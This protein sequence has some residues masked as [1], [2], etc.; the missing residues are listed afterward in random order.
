M[1]KYYL[2]QSISIGGFNKG[3]LKEYILEGE[4]I[5]LKSQAGYATKIPFGIVSLYFNIRPV[6]EHAKFPPAESPAI[7]IYSGLML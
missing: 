6:K 2:R 3:S 4:N 5:L 7:T 1:F